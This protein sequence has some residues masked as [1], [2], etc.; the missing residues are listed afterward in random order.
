MRWISTC[1][2]SRQW[3][4]CAHFFVLNIVIYLLPFCH[5]GDSTS[6]VTNA[7]VSVWFSWSLSLFSTNVALLVWIFLRISVN[8]VSHFLFHPECNAAIHKKCIEMII[9]R[10]TGT[11]TNSRDTMVSKVN[12]CKMSTLW[13]WRSLFYKWLLLFCL[14]SPLWFQ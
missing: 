9:G 1:S 14:L 2:N 7:D 8:A 10:C 12:E 3:W 4:L 11:A 5:E 6:K 13:L